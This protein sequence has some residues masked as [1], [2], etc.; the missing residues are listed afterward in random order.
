[1]QCRVWPSSDWQITR[2]VSIAFHRVC[3]SHLGR[4]TRFTTACITKR[5]SCPRTSDRLR[6]KHGR[7]W[8]LYASL[9]S[10]CDIFAEIIRIDIL[11]PI[12]YRADLIASSVYTGEK[13]Q[14]TERARIRVFQTGQCTMICTF[15]TS[16]GYGSVLILSR[17]I[18]QSTILPTW[19][20]YGSHGEIHQRD[21]IAKRIPHF[22][23]YHQPRLVY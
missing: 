14:V 6:R 11:G 15:S 22:L 12:C 1:M 10:V 2:S 23:M 9:C 13:G 20:E 7:H 17:Q 4:G 5:R 19:Y 21:H 8:E 18:S 3:F 16:C